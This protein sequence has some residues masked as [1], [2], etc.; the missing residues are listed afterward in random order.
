MR[1][2][3]F[4]IQKL[5]RRMRPNRSSR[6]FPLDVIDASAMYTLYVFDQSRS[7]T[8]IPSA[9]YLGSYI[10]YVFGMYSPQPYTGLPSI[11]FQDYADFSYDVCHLQ[12]REHASAKGDLV[13]SGIGRS[14]GL[15]RIESACV[16]AACMNSIS[17]V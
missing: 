11:P 17:V 3:F 6:T 4:G 8:A 1:L 16:V 2:I 12:R 13:E 10:G 9:G 15:G 7:V 14:S 5:M